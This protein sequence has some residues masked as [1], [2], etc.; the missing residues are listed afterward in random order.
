[1]KKKNSSRTKAIHYADHT[2]PTLC[3]ELYSKQHQT[4]RHVRQVIIVRGKL[5]V[6]PGGKDSIAFVTPD[7]NCGVEAAGDV[8]IQNEK[9]RNRAL[10]GDVVYVE[11]IIDESAQDD[12]NTNDYVDGNDDDDDGRRD[13]TKKKNGATIT[14]FMTDLKLNG[15]KEEKEREEKE[16]KVVYEEDDYLID[17]GDDK[18]NKVHDDNNAE[19][20]EE[21]WH[22][23]MTQMSLWNPTIKLRK[24]KLTINNKEEGK[25]TELKQ[26]QQQQRRGRVICII[27]LTTP[28]V[29]LQQSSSETGVVPEEVAKG[30]GKSNSNSNNN[31][32]NHGGR[33]NRK[34]K[35]EDN[36]NND[37]ILPKRIIIGTLTQLDGGRYLLVPTNKCYPRFM[38]PYGTKPHQP[39]QDDDVS[40]SGSNNRILYRATYAYNTWATTMK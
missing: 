28:L 10:H 20:G 39:S 2:S 34:K 8:L 16:D 37:N 3:F 30:S 4:K 36:N 35:N 13:M 33:N 15:E 12:N 6:L 14:N 31:H 23:D 22:D 26:Q 25:T 11:L 38:C 27:P 32:H 24:N 40:S 1:M 18:N 19:N 17:E 29:K 21:M 5:R 7:N 9:D